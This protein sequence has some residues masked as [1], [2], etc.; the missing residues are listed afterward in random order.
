MSLIRATEE[1]DEVSFKE[2]LSSE[3]ALLLFSVRRLPLKFGPSHFSTHAAFEPSSRVY[4]ADFH[5]VIRKFSL[6]TRNRAHQNCH[7]VHWRAVAS[8]Y[9][10]T[11]GRSA[12]SESE[13]QF[14]LLQG[15][16]IFSS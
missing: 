6:N 4:S 8:H 5:P 9:Q 10:Q 16:M 13:I 14:C 3:K 7:L 2:P 12:V 1:C 11:A 15:R